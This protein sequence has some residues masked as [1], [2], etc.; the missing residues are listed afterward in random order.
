MQNL[1]E[2]VFTII[3]LYIQGE[4]IV[5]YLYV[6]KREEKPVYT[7]RMCGSSHSSASS[8]RWE[9]SINYKKNNNFLLI[10]NIQAA[11][12]V[13]ICAV[14]Q[15]SAIFCSIVMGSKMSTG[16]VTMDVISAPT[17]FCIDLQ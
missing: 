17:Y 7:N 15:T 12:I 5:V 2:K 3:D 9:Y 14:R 13:N 6:Q 8:K 16:R 1:N 4:G 10:A 11:Y